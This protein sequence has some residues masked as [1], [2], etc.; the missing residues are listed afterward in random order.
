MKKTLI[1]A[2]IALIITAGTVSLVNAQMQ[3]KG[4]YNRPELSEE[5]KAQIE[6]H[7]IEREERREEMEKVITNGTYKEWKALVDNRPKITDYI[8]ADNFAKFQEAHKLRQSGDYEGA[9]KIMEELG[10]EGKFG[11]IAKKGMPGQPRG[12]RQMNGECLQQ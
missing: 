3:E 10:I 5:M 4:N 11:M 1:I 12:M 9:R 2:A 8:N 6:K 7:E